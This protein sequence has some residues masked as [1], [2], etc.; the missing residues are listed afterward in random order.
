MALEYVTR[1]LGKSSD[2]LSDGD[3]ATLSVEAIKRCP[4]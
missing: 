1:R 2:S 4:L 3:E